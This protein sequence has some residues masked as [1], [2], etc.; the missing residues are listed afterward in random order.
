MERGREGGHARAI[1]T[2]GGTKEPVDEVRFL[3]NFS[4]GRFGYAIAGCMVEAGYNV[5]VLCARE[6]PALAGF[7]LPRVE[8][9]NFTSAESLQQALLG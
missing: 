6:V 8:H 3:T 9:V 5:T 4:T 2:T 7:E 1:I